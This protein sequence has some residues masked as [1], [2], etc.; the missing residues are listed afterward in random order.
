M[1]VLGTF[2]FSIKSIFIKLAYD[3]GANPEA[4]L[5]LRQLIATPLFWG[6]LLSY[7]ANAVVAFQRKDIWK[8]ASAGV[9]GFFLSPLLDFLGLHFVSAIVERM[10]LFT[11]PMFV[12]M[13]TALMK[14]K[15]I[16]PQSFFAL[17]VIYAGIFLA[18]GGWNISLLKANMAGA[19]L[20]IAS[21][22][23]YAAYLVLS[24]QLVH[25]LGVIRLNTY[26][27]TIATLFMS[28]YL[29]AKM[30][31]EE[32]MGLFQYS[33]SVYVYFF[34]IAII[35]TVISCLLMFEGIKIIGAE[36]A[37]LIS[38]TGPIITIILGAAFLGEQ[39][40]WIQWIGCAIV[41]S[42]A[43]YVELRNMSERA[44][45]SLKKKG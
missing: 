11:Y 2:C 33:A 23:T 7:R 40:E 21:S 38:L 37:S 10:L 6:I 32:F 44:N 25:S 24:G 28:G 4:T 13:I 36:R 8:T 42:A 26:G 41:F 27:M 35:S 1:V 15:M 9:L 45:V 34:V 19:L 17:L 16:P 29:A 39:L 12:V 3:K 31:R 5:F 20:I 18:I 22:I 30:D 14:K 43:V